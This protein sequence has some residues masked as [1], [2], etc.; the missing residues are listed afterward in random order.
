MQLSYSSSL[1]WLFV[2]NIQVSPVR[3]SAA[4]LEKA[5]DI[6]QDPELN[7]VIITIFL[8]QE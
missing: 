3:I 7:K 6:S 1:N 8:G 5:W 4:E 2:F